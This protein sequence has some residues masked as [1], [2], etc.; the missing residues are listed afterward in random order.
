MLA[1]VAA[2][3]RAATGLQVYQ[4]FAETLNS[5]EDEVW[6][7]DCWA[8][9]R[10]FLEGN[11]TNRLYPIFPESFH[12]VSDFP[13]VTLLLAKREL[14]FISRFGAMQIQRKQLDD[15]FGEQ[16]PFRARGEH[17]IFDKFDTMGDGVWHPKNSR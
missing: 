11:R 7:R 9:P 16:V 13:G 15:R 10:S 17:V 6:G 1:Q 4:Q 14:V 12:P 5:F 3:P 8:P 2:L